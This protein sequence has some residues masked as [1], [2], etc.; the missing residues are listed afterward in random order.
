MP[1]EE[2]NQGEEGG[3][4]GSQEPTNTESTDQGETK[5]PEDVGGYNAK[6]EVPPEPT[7]GYN[8]DG[9]AAKVDAPPPKVD[10]ENP[11]LNEIDNLD[12]DRRT[13]LQEFINKN[14]LSKAQIKSLIGLEK[15]EMSRR[16]ELFDAEDRA[17]QKKVQ[18]ERQ[19]YADELKRDQ[20]YGGANFQDTLSKVN[21][22]QEMGVTKRIM[23]MA[24]DSGIMLHPDIMRDLVDIHDALLKTDPH[25]FG[26]AQQKEK[27]SIDAFYYSE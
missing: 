13:A 1:E 25:G 11:S 23:K 21:K 8:E 7:G 15:S 20:K 12:E 14:Q 27:S 22:L 6:H 4:E 5:E 17:F 18:E 3:Q 10:P 9:T 16:Q 19:A 24:K 2:N 26:M